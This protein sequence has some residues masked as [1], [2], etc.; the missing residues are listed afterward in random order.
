MGTQVMTPVFSH[1]L[2]HVPGLHA[3]FALLH[4][5]RLVLHAEAEVQLQHAVGALTGK[6]SEVWFGGR[7]VWE[8]RLYSRVANQ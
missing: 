7:G 3:R 5:H 4:A 2:P 6:V 1:F 8:R